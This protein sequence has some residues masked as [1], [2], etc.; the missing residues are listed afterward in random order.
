MARLG[1][2]ERIGTITGDHFVWGFRNVGRSIA[3]EDMGTLSR[4]CWEGDRGK[5]HWWVGV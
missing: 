5:W 1:G 3:K 4:D 2:R